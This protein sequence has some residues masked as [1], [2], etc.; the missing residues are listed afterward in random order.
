CVEQVFVT[1]ERGGPRVPGDRTVPHHPDVTAGAQSAVP[2]PVEED[3]DH[4]VVLL[5]CDEGGLHLVDQLV[6]ECV[7]GPRTVEGDTAEPP[8][9]SGQDFVLGG[10]VHRMPPRNRC[11][12]MRLMLSLFPSTVLCGRGP[13]TPLRTVSRF[14]AYL[15]S[16]GGGNDQRAT[17]RNSSCAR[18]RWSG[19]TSGVSVMR[20]AVSSQAMAACAARTATS[21]STPTSV[22]AP[23]RR[24]ALCCRVSR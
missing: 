21:S 19:K 9:D 8:L 2:G 12:T 11:A 6:I 14:R 1:P 24:P 5:P 13:R 15:G 4:V 18:S 17:E 16:L 22:S 10:V 7:D 3:G 20:M 23:A